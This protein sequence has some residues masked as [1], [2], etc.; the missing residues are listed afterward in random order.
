MADV[1]IDLSEVQKEISALTPEQI[2][3]KLTKIRVRDKVQQ[4]RNYN[5]ESAK[6]YQAKARAEKQALKDM[7]IKLGLWDDIN[8]SAEEQAEQKLAEEALTG[9]DE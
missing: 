6:A 1:T 8:K 4:K 9:Q 3:E 7:A 5:S 2:R